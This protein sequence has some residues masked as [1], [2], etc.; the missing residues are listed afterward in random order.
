HVQQLRRHRDPNFQQFAAGMTISGGLDLFAEVVQRVPGVYAEREK[1]T[2]QNLWSYAIEELDRALGKPTFRD[3]FLDNP[4]ADKLADFR[5]A[6]R[7]DWAKRSVT[8]HKEARS[9]L[10]QLIAAAQDALPVRV[11]SALAVE[12]ACGACSGLDEYT[13]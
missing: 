3:A 9:Q 4:R 5:A 8:N 2:P 12:C 10:R 1:A 6:L 13:V 11:P 7:R